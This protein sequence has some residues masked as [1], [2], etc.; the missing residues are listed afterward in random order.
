MPEGSYYRLED[1]GPFWKCTLDE[2][3]LDGKAW[4][5]GLC[6]LTLLR[7][8]IYPVGLESC[9]PRFSSGFFVSRVYPS[10]YYPPKDDCCYTGVISGAFILLSEPENPVALAAPLFLFILLAIV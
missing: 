1:L 6:G 7:M 4:Y 2:V 8:Y 5:V 10:I 3:G 9:L